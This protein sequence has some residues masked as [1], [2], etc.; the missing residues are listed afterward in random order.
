MLVFY[1]VRGHVSLTEVSDKLSLSHVYRLDIFESV[2]FLENVVEIVVWIRL[3]FR[4]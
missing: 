1:G 4:W 3:G 2:L